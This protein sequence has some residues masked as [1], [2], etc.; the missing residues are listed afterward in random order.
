MRILLLTQW[1]DPEPTFKGLAFAQA[2]SAAGH[3]VEVITGFPNYPGGRIYPG[4]KLRWLAREVIDGIRINRVPLYPSHDSSAI[5]RVLNYLSFA[6]ASCLCG[7]F[8]ARRPDVI[9]TYHPPLTTALSGLVIA[10][11]RRAPMVMDIQDLWPD[12]LRATGMIRSSAVLGLVRRICGFVYARCTALAVLSPGFKRALVEGGVPAGKIEVIYNWCDERA[13]ALGA[14]NVEVPAAMKGRFNIVFAGTMGKAQALDA[15][16]TAATKVALTDAR[17]Q[18]VFVGGGIEVE[19]L[20]AR[21]ASQ[22][23]GNVMFLPRMP[24]NEVGIVLHA[25]DALLVHLKDDPLF[26]IT[27]PSKTQ[28]YMAVGRPVIMAVRGDAAELIERSGGG[29][30]AA[31][32]DADSIADAAL[33]L[34]AMSPADRAAM[35]GRAA[36]YYSEHMA[37]RI[38]AR[39]FEDLFLRVVRP[40]HSSR[41]P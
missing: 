16:L 11:L 31:P 20:K 26:A 22:A 7:V 1:F 39:Q 10:L 40:P 4:Y 6:A 23:I 37:L 28:A 3:D 19:R 33:R 13:L 8:G 24:M 14:E 36:R 25:A 12:T 41:N 18:F 2:L 27:V 35:G 30:T 34:A 21:V 17:V 5:G 9:Y 32:E 29:L 15:V 38:G